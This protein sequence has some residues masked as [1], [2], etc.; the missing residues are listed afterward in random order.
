MRLMKRNLKP[1]YYRL[2][3][4]QRNTLDENG[5]ETGDKEIIYS[6]PAMQRCNVSP[7]SGA[8]QME[9]FGSVENYDKIL[10]TDNMDCPINE[11]TVLFIAETPQQQAWFALQ[12]PMGNLDENPYEYVVKRIARSL[13]HIS[14][15]VSKV[16]VS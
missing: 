13:H 11:N 8:I 9:L 15:A 4:G 5:Y 2:Y 10:L 14:Y 12:F 1:V 16:K 3:L 7:A 6:D